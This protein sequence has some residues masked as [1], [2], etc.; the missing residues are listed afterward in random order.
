ME[1][2]E[3]NKTLQSTVW[4]NKSRI[5]GIEMA[6]KYLKDSIDE[7]KNNHLAHIKTS[8]DKINEEVLTLRLSQSENSPI[9]KIVYKAVE[10]IVI[11]VIMAALAFSGKGG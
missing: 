9:I 8:L 7:I 2:E 6:Q 1:K 11:A 5:D 4:N 10:Y 3:N